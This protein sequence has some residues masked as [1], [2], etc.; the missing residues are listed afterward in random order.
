MMRRIA[1]SLLR[2]IVENGA[3]FFA[4]YVLGVLCAVLTLPHWRGA[5]LYDHLFS[6]LF[7]DVYV[8]CVLLTLLPRKVRLWVRRAL[9]VVLYAVGMV[10]VYCFWKFGSTLTPTM[11]LLV[12]ET[13]AREA[14]EFFHAYLT[15]EVF[16]SPVGWL[17]AHVAAGQPRQ[18]GALARLGG[19]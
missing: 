9:Y 14:S 11:L 5:H 10:D 12:G 4:M 1:R 8:T 3:F 16:F 13:D 15:P 6:E 7:L 19:S 18:L 2:P 17:L